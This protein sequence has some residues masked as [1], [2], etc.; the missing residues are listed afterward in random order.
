MRNL[1]TW[2]TVSGLTEDEEQIKIWLEEIKKK[3]PRRGN[4]TKI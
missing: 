2:L 1:K 3:Q 4:K